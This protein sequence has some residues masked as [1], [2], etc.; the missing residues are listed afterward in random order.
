MIC[1][2]V[3]KKNV[4]KKENEKVC[5]GFSQQFSNSSEL[6]FSMNDEDHRK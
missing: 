5:P 1:D 3:I 6:N 2:N 4:P